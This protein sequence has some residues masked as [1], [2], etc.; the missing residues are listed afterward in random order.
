MTSLKKHIIPLQR[1]SLDLAFNIQS[2][3]T[4][5]YTNKNIGIELDRAIKEAIRIT[6][7]T[8]KKESTTVLDDKSILRRFEMEGFSLKDDDWFLNEAIEDTNFKGFG[9]HEKELYLYLGKIDKEEEY[10][11]YL[12][13]LDIVLFRSEKKYQELKQQY[14][15]VQKNIERVKQLD[16]DGIVSTKEESRSRQGVRSKSSRIY[17]MSRQETDFRERLALMEH[18]HVGFIFSHNMKNS[19]F[20]K[21]AEA[22]IGRYD[23][24]KLIYNEGNEL[25]IDGLTLSFGLTN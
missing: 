19:D 20:I 24:Y 25:A 12:E 15:Y 1:E 3:D 18:F 2:Y 13:D 11:S 5:K 4:I 10:N 17:E 22:I 21:R 8:E 14:E 9:Q 16:E 23:K 7:Q 6:G